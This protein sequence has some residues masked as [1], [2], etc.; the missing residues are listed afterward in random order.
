M[1]RKAARTAPSSGHCVPWSKRMLALRTRKT[2]PEHISVR[3]ICSSVP[4]RDS[5]TAISAMSAIV[6]AHSSSG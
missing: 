2:S 1:P 4:V 6:L 3:N 5:S